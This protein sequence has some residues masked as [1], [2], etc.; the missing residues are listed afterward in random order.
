MKSTTKVT[1]VVQFRTSLQVRAWL[2]TR[3]KILR[4]IKKRVEAHLVREPKELI[5]YRKE[6]ERSFRRK[7]QLSDVA[8]LDNQMRSAQIIFAG[9]FHAFSQAQRMHLKIL[10]RYPV[11]QEVTIALESTSPRQNKIVESFLNSEISESI[12]L[13]KMQWNET[14]GFP[15]ENYRPLFELARDRKFRII[16]LS[17]HYKNKSESLKTRDRVAAQFLVRELKKD[18]KRKIYV[19][20]GD[21][22]IAQKHLPNEFKFQSLKLGLKISRLSIFLNPEV[23][24]FKLAE[25]GLENKIEIVRLSSNQYCVMGSPPWV[26][27]QSY[28]M[29]LERSTD[30]MLQDEDPEFDPTDEVRALVELVCSDLNLK[31]ATNELAVYSSYNEKI[32]RLIGRQVAK[33]DFKIVDELIEDGRS[34]CFSQS[35]VCYLARPSVNHVAE[36]AGQYLHAKISKRKKFFWN[37]PTDFEKQIW[38]EAMSF[39]LSKLINHKRYSYSLLDLN[40]KLREN[41][42]AGEQ[43]ILKLALD[44]RMGEVL[45]LHHM[46]K[47][48]QSFM[49]R[50]KTSYLFAA[51][52]LGSMMGERLYI[53]LQSNKIK[54]DEIV[55]FLKF[56]PQHADFM[57]FYSKILRWLEPVHLEMKSRKERL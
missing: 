48:K 25:K 22:H 14:W 38:C 31:V 11:G 57:E 6:Y 46:K 20:F 49:P 43:E 34:I 35:G 39:F 10:R 18:P 28:L 37:M 23:I 47:R 5:Y 15:W 4:Q 12:F 52:I 24:Y 29:Y 56:D 53:A 51:R 50:R 40:Q 32:W 3:K 17:N 1:A 36:L 7:F 8:D 16:G 44:H 30:Q 45:F 13:K 54:L 33:K 42:S 26:Q 21:L 19:L 2:N 27:W 9:D 55:D 41:A